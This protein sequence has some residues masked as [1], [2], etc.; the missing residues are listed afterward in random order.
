MR[1]DKLYL[2]QISSEPQS[3]SSCM[4]AEPPRKPITLDE[5]CEESGRVDLEGSPAPAAEF[6]VEIL[7]IGDN[8]VVKVDAPSALIKTPTQIT[9][10][11]GINRRSLA[12]KK[13]H[14]VPQSL[15]RER[16]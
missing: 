4:V 7:E 6:W 16:D 11:R 2:W 14:H 3:A 12:K 10:F 8:D 9:T 15:M 1:R 13:I 5:G